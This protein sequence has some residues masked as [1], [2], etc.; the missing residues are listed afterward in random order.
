MSYDLTVLSPE[1][2]ELLVADLLSREFGVQLERFKAGKD[3]G[4]DLRHTRIVQG[5]QVSMIV[6]CKRYAPHRYVGLIRAMEQELPKLSLLRPERYLLATSVPLS[7]SNKNELLKLLHPWCHTPG[8]IYGATEILALIRKFPEVERAH[9]KLWISSTAVLERVIHSRI[10]NLTEATVEAAREQMSRLVMHNG[11]RR[12]LDV[13][14]E[15]HHA[16][17]VGNPGIGKTTLARML[18]CHY[19]QQ[20]FEPLV[21]T[22]DIG[23]AWT[24][25]QTGKDIHR[26][27]VVLY[28]DFLGQLR[29]DSVRFGKNEELSLHEFLEKV[30]RLDRLR[31]ILTTREYILADARRVH[32]V[33]AEEAERMAR[34]TVSLTDY[35]QAH[36]ALVLFNHLYFS[37][38]PEGRLHKLVERR[39]YQ[40]IIKHKHFSPRI[41]EGISNYANS[42][43]MSD[44]EY[45]AYIEHEFDDPRVVWDHPFRYQ[46]SPTSRQLL[47]L[48]WSFGSHVELEDL[49]NSLVRLNAAQPSE[50]VAQRWYDSLRELDGNFLSTNRY[51]LNRKTSK[52]VIIVEFQNPSI[53]EFVEGFVSEEPT[54]LERLSEAI[55]SFSQVS[56]LVS[57]ATQ[58]GEALSKAAAIAFW[59]RLDEA[60]RQLESHPTSRFITETGFRGTDPSREWR[61]FER[62]SIPKRTV[63][64]LKIAQQMPN[65]AASHRELKERLTSQAGWEDLLNNV[66]TDDTVPHAIEQLIEWVQANNY[67]TS[68]EKS[69]VGE[70][71]RSYLHP[72]LLSPDDLSPISVNSIAELAK[73]QA[74]FNPEFSSEE[75]AAFRTAVLAAAEGAYDDL[76]DSGALE[77]E[78]RAVKEVSEFFG[79]DLTKTYDRLMRR[80][81]D[82]EETEHG[83]YSSPEKG[84]YIAEAEREQDIDALFADLIN[85]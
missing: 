33:F 11:F 7:P 38:L 84:R 74:L 30:R 13:L 16:L 53:R 56:H 70:A 44:E 23:D 1:D 85:R 27:F 54:W 24:A 69:E 75:Q 77:S 62:P 4:I 26:K 60:G 71:F 83:Y 28:D 63:T 8:D 20:G 22:G 40:R 73:A 34:C 45:L 58:G 37:G 35:T 29:F 2:F 39:V 57:H 25:I 67:L 76:D 82:R 47:I 51:P 36:R 17:I 78:A 61:N 55:V 59:S 66:E 14:G 52:T 12:A 43:S 41:V 18:M 6:Q 80:A 10:F 81:Q 48:L 32:G 79:F 9:F 3:S 50:E 64:R 21:V 72:L 68:P 46:I 15:H 31:F 5:R 42:R 19:L 65:D 49:R